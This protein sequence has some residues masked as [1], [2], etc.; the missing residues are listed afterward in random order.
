MASL[1][2]F[3]SCSLLSRHLMPSGMVLVM[4]LRLL[5]QRTAQPSD[6]I[7][8]TKVFLSAAYFMHSSMVFMSRSFQLWPF[9]AV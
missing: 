4:Y 8:E 6:A 9:S 7:S 5:S 2:Y 3:S 1:Q